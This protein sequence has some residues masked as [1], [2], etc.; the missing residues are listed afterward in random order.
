MISGTVSETVLS[1]S[2]CDWEHKRPSGG[3]FK[4]GLALGSAGLALARL[5]W[6][7]QMYGRMEHEKEPVRFSE[8]TTNLVNCDRKPAQY[9]GQWPMEVDVWLQSVLKLK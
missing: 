2:A 1:L 6:C 5:Q 8:G 3:A 4:P 9:A 7:D